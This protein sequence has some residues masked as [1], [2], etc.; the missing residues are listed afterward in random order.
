MSLA[1]WPSFFVLLLANRENASTAAFSTANEVT[2]ILKFICRY[3]ARYEK[4][5]CSGPSDSS[6]LA[7]AYAVDYV[8]KRFKMQPSH[9]LSH[10]LPSPS[11]SPSPVCKSRLFALCSWKFCVASTR[12]VSSTS[13]IAHGKR[14]VDFLQPGILTCLR[15]VGYSHPSLPPHPRAPDHSQDHRGTG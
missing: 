1:W 10:L 15:I 13:T 4:K 3:D 2:E 9:Q 11:P 8:I 12:V 6:G 14:K 7:L 5:C